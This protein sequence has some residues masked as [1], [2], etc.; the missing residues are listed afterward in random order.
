MQS[1][2]SVPLLSRCSCAVPVYTVMFSTGQKTIVYF[3]LEGAVSCVVLQSSVGCS[4]AILFFCSLVR[5]I[6]RLHCR[7]RAL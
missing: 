1:T 6:L 7:K 3:S 4:D 5:D 2:Q